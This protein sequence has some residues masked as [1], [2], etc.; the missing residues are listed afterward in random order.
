MELYVIGVNYKT[1]PIQIREKFSVESDEYEYILSSI[2]SL[3]GIMECA[4]LS[5]CN[6]TELH[7]FSEN[8]IEDT[9]YIE[10]QFCILKGLDIYEVKKYFY[11]YSDINAIRHI[12][13]VASGMD[14]MI[15]GEEQIL[16][17]FKSAYEISIKYGTSKAV[18]NTLSRLAIT[19]SKK[20][21]TRNL[22]LNKVT[23]VAGQAVLLI[24]DIYGESVINRNILIIGSGEI[25]K[26]I[27]FKLQEL[28]AAKIYITQRNGLLTNEI[29]QSKVTIINYKDRYSYIRESDVVIGAT[30]SPH[31]IIT[32]DMLEKEIVN[33]NKKQLFIDL[34]V[35][36]DFDEA[37]SKNENIELY[38]IDQ[39]KKFKL[40]N[41][42]DHGHSQLDMDYI[43]TQIN[44]HINEFIRW[45]KYR[46]SLLKKA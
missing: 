1:T 42:K 38:N 15:I 8:T 44:C 21:H 41:V 22:F 5:T 24:E 3:D 2:K 14:S 4:L 33:S 40:K 31:Y 27:C 29:N 20:F 18:L 9:G 11:V 10:K 30:S 35:P 19:A 6:R 36:R 26:T 32:Q 23:S 12:M 7:I 17:Q 13:K 28:G 34:A 46:N 37:I 16:G 39:L 25:G 43:E 45:Y